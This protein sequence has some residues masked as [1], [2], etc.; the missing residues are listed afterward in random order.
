[1]CSVECI[2][3][4]RVHDCSHA[5]KYNAESSKQAQSWGCAIWAKAY[6]CVE[7]QYALCLMKL[8]CLGQLEVSICHDGSLLPRD[9]SIC[10]PDAARKEPSIIVYWSPLKVLHVKLHMPCQVHLESLAKQ[11]HPTEETCTSPENGQMKV[12]W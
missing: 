3:G 1:M 5:A 4:A 6:G 8:I 9:G 2:S 7:L 12:L 10:L 11:H